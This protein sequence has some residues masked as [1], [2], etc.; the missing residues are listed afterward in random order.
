MFL[1][2]V[3]VIVLVG[4]LNAFGDAFRG[5]EAGFLLT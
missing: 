5:L 3:G 1:L 2:V 4:V